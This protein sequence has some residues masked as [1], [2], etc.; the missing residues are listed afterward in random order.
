MSFRFQVSGFKFSGRALALARG[1][2]NLKL[3]T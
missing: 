2:D 3:E 1:S